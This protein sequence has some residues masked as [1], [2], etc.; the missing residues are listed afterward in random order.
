MDQLFVKQSKKL[1]IK[2]V[3]QRS[4][5]AELGYQAFSIPVMKSNLDDDSI[6]YRISNALMSTNTNFNDYGY[7]FFINS[8][9]TENETHCFVDKKD[10]NYE[11]PFDEYYWLGI[12]AMSSVFCITVIHV[13]IAKCC[14]DKK[15]F[16]NASTSSLELMSSPGT[17][18]IENKSFTSRFQ[19]D[20]ELI[21]VLGRGGFGV[22]MEV[23]NKIDDC[24]YA[25]KRIRI[26]FSGKSKMMQLDFVMREVKALAKLDHPGIVRYFNAW[27][28]NPPKGWQESKDQEQNIVDITQNCSNA[29]ESCASYPN[30]RTVSSNKVKVLNKLKENPLNPFKDITLNNLQSDSEIVD[31]S[32]SMQNSVGPFGLFV[33]PS[34][35]SYSSSYSENSIPDSNVSFSYQNDVVHPSVP[36]NSG[37]KC[38]KTVNE[39]NILAEDLVNKNYNIG[40]EKNESVRQEEICGT[41]IHTQTYDIQS[42]LGGD[43]VNSFGADFRYSEQVALCE[44]NVQVCHSNKLSHK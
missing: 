31:N 29:S 40:R 10:D 11:E 7:Y 15:E 37:S 2:K 25:V 36:K 35:L 9:V 21:A 13:A 33:K 38:I 3:S 28:E 20:F 39:A 5:T 14:L 41:E 19:E 8:S 16:V 24:Y 30:K 22:V 43:C 18:A 1:K 17:N 27:V 44:N 4:S 12:I 26:H 23:K 42:S 6:K 34:D 32:H